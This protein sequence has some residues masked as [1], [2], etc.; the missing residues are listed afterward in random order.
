M[1]KALIIVDVQNDFVEGGSLAVT[2]GVSVAERLAEWLKT[3]ADDYNLITTT[4]DWHIDP[5]THFSKEP[6]F[7]TTWPKH[8]VAKTD[9]AKIVAPLQ[10]ALDNLPTHIPFGQVRKGM[11]DD[12][13]SGFQGQVVENSKREPRF[14]AELLREHVVTHVD[15]VGIATDHCVKESALD[16]VAEGFDT[17]VLMEFCAGITPETVADFVDNIAPEKGIT[18]R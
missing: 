9:G 2:G 5:G 1:T 15:I 3:H 4:Q 18:I 13:Y 10:E 7:V 17:T 11:Y 16:A 8:C 12:A 14:L 6:N